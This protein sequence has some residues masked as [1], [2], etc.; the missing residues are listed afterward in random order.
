MPDK[1]KDSLHVDL[2]SFAL[3]LYIQQI[4]K[5]S[6]R[7]S[8]VSANAELV[9]HNFIWFRWPGNNSRFDSESHRTVS[10]KFFRVS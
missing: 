5:I 2:L 6:L 10:M 1:Y 8:A 3:F 7:A 4:N 9:I